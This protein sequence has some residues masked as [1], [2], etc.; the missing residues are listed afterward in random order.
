MCDP[1][2]KQ[3]KQII[4]K[5]VFFT[6]F[7]LNWTTKTPGPLSTHK[8][9]QAKGWQATTGLSVDLTGSSDSKRGPFKYP[10]FCNIC[11]LKNLPPTPQPYGAL[12]LAAS[13]LNQKRFHIHCQHREHRNRDRK[14]DRCQDRHF[15]GSLPLTGWGWMTPCTHFSDQATPASSKRGNSTCHLTFLLLV[16]SQASSK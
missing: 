1:K 2:T 7:F 5:E 12:A 15:L 8:W 9:S 11:L 13:H 16:R 6:L 3:N 4:L 14:Q 10:F